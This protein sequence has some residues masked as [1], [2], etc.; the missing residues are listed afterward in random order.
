MLLLITMSWDKID[1]NLDEQKLAIVKSVERRKVQT[2][3]K[4]E[5]E[6]QFIRC[7]IGLA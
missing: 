2:K 5:M 6:K 3:Q 7:H 1:D 4:N